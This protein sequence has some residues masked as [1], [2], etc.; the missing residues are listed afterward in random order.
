M[1]LKSL[2]II[3][4]GGLRDCHIDLK[5]GLN[6]IS[7]ANESGKSS[8]AMFIKFVFY[9]LSGKNTRALP[10]ERKR[11]VN[12]ETGQAAG[13]IIAVTDSGEEYRLERA[14]ITSDNAAP[15]ERVRIINQRS[16]ECIT[17]QN[18]GEYFFGV[19]EEVFVD[20]CFISQSAAIRPSIGTDGT[21]GAVENLL[22]SVNEN[23]D[24][25]KA[26]SRLDE[27]RRALFHKH[28]TGGEIKEL[29]EKR[30]ALQ[31]ELDTARDKSAEI[32]TITIS[33]EDVNRRLASLEESRAKYED[34][35][36]ALEKISLQRKFDSVN[37]SLSSIE[38]LER[39]IS[40]ID[41]SIFGDGFEDVIAE[42]ERDIRAYDEKCL[43]YDNLPTEDDTPHDELPYPEEIA[44]EAHSLET[45]SRIHFSVAIALLIAGVIGLGAVVL[46]YYFN[47]DMYLLP[48]IMTV[49]LVSLGIVFIT[50][51]AKANTSLNLLL[52]EWDAESADE[53]ENAVQETLSALVTDTPSLP[54]RDTF[55]I[56]LE[57][58]KLRFDTA[59]ERISEMAVQANIEEFEDIYETIDALRELAD[60]TYA[61]KSDMLAKL[62]NLRGRLDVLEE[63]LEGV[64]PLTVEVEAS[65]ASSTPSGMI[66]ASLSAA[67]IKNY[68]R[69][70]DFTENAIRASIKQKS[71]LEASLAEIGRP[72]ADP[73]ELATKLES[74]DTL[75]DELTL[76]HD[77]CEL[78]M[79]AITSA[80]HSMRSEII[81]QIASR[82]SEMIQKA[83]GGAHDALM[84][85]KS[86]AAGISSGDDVITS[87]LLSR[88]TSDLSYI[89]LRI[90]IAEKLF[91]NE[92]PIMVFD[93]SF[94]HIDRVRTE[95]TFGL[96][97]NNQYVILTCRSDDTDAAVK[98]GANVINL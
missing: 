8:A 14:L 40:D 79:E 16:G 50:K 69:E 43:E 56:S 96:L 39:S 19:P 82:A 28:R 76:R 18:P 68:Q 33:L 60:G 51:Y 37:E 30:A 9:G 4:F 41:E 42:A 32:I 29:R 70:R 64:D 44:E 84:L 54:D 47:T 95:A 91:A 23:V 27:T 74:I 31:E 7:G 15:R 75:I 83:T 66:A 59:C 58:A 38:E 25:K 3:S 90:S 49:A 55:L 13:Y 53:I 81:P 93:E 71:S 92:T 6:V 52:D 45:T 89:A 65:A 46:L 26:V 5:R 2:H 63:Q 1:I 36:D 35:F 80:G 73:S 87:A 22:T 11:Y 97:S 86:F 57:N 88:G 72:S 48:L 98:T 21:K 10:S 24:I 17:G 61:E 12:R 34:I 77:A 94:A 20:T 78:A 67:E 62:G 85:D